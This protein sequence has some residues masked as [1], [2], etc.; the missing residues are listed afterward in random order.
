MESPHLTNGTKLH[1]DEHVYR[2]GEE[3]EKV[4][5]TSRREE[6]GKKEKDEK[7]ERVIR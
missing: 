4:G 3:E 7:E 1:S 2:K 5:K 6:L